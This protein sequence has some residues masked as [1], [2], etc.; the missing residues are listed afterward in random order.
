MDTIGPKAGLATEA[1]IDGDVRVY[2]PKSRQV[3]VLNETAA[4]VWRLC[5]GTRTRREI[6]ETLAARYREE[7]P[8]VLPAITALIEQFTRH[9]L[10]EMTD[11]GV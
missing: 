1:A 4:D 3:L 7:L 10:F 9:G 11:E 6:A 5:D 8:V 2:A